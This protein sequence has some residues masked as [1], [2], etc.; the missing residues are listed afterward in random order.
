MGPV[1]STGPI[2]PLGPQGPQGIQGEL[3][4]TGLQGLAGPLGLQGPT[5]NMGSTPMALAFGRFSINTDGELLIE[6][7]GAANNN[8]FTIT[9]NGDLEVTV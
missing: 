8:D 3:G 6:H 4:A 9:S 1:G 7:Y 2:G 5:G